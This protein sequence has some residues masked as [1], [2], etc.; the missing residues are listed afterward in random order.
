[1]WE[2]QE[3]LSPRLRATLL[4]I[5]QG[6]E[7]QLVKYLAISSTQTV[8]ESSLGGPTA[9]ESLSV[10]SYTSKTSEVTA[11]TD[12]ARDGD[13]TIVMTFSNLYALKERMVAV[14]SLGW[15]S[16]ILKASHHSLQAMLP[17]DSLN[18]VE[19]FYA[20]TVCTFW[21]CFQSFS[22]FPVRDLDLSPCF[23]NDLSFSC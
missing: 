7:E 14:E 15:I 3:V 18:S 23:K 9:G 2:C 5:S 1:M 8:P 11:D 10:S 17:Q 12:A 13:A 21:M 4:R 22:F 20:C 19:F 6:L 16:Q